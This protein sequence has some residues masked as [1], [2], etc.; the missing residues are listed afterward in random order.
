MGLCNNGVI[1]AQ[2][3]RENRVIKEMREIRLQ[4]G[5]PMW[6]DAGALIRQCIIVSTVFELLT[7]I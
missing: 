1:Q 2:D 7:G 5:G 6:G 4:E 3:D